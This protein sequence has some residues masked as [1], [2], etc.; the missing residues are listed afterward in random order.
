MKKNPF[1]KI[2]RQSPQ[3]QQQIIEALVN[4]IRKAPLNSIVEVLQE[5][6]LKYSFDFKTWLSS[7]QLE[8]KLTRTF[9]SYLLYCIYYNEL[10]FLQFDRLDKDQKNF[11]LLKLYFE[12]DKNPQLPKLEE[13]QLLLLAADCIKSQRE[14]SYFILQSMEDHLQGSAWRT[15]LRRLKNGY[16]SSESLYKHAQ[17]KSATF[18]EIDAKMNMDAAD[19]V[20]RI[21]KNLQ[22]CL[23]GITTVPS[24]W[25]SEKEL[26]HLN[27]LFKPFLTEKYTV[28]EAA[29]FFEIFG[30]FG[31][32]IEEASSSSSLNG[33]L[34][35]F[36]KLIKDPT[37]LIQHFSPVLFFLLSLSRQLYAFLR[38]PEQYLKGLERITLSVATRGNNLKNFFWIT[39]I[40]D[41]L[42]TLVDHLHQNGFTQVQ[43]S[44]FPLYVFDEYKTN[45]Q[46]YN[47][48]RKKYNATIH[49]IFYPTLKKVADLLSLTTSIFPNNS[50]KLGYAGARNCSLMLAPYLAKDAPEN[51]C[52][53]DAPKHYR[54]I[55]FEGAVNLPF[56]HVGEDDVYIP[57]SG[58]FSDALYAYYYSD[59][60]IHRG[61]M[62]YGRAGQS[63]QL[64]Q[65]L[66]SIIN[67][68]SKAFSST[69]W[70][71][72]P[73]PVL[74]SGGL[75]K[76][77]FCLNLPF[78]AEELHVNC[79][80]AGV[81]YFQ[82]PVIHLA[83]TR[84][85][86]KPLPN[87]PLDGIEETLNVS[88]PYVACVS[89]VINLVDPANKIF[90][91]ILPWNEK[92]LLDSKALR[93]L[94]EMLLFA[95]ADVVTSDIKKRFWRNMGI[96]FNSAK[97]QKGDFR[98]YMETLVNLDEKLAVS[99][100]LMDFYRRIKR[101]AKLFLE[102]GRKTLAY[103]Y[104]GIA[105]PHEKAFA[106]LGVTEMDEM[107]SAL[108][109]LI[110]RVVNETLVPLP[111]F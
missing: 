88:L 63:L 71:D 21:L 54:A 84:F 72:K 104:E 98:E 68:P 109:M 17:N 110:D 79:L 46:F 45:S 5:L 38:A 62:R 35:D 18:T 77:K 7:V 11:F 6:F 47:K 8:G 12:N 4:S 57:L 16:Y 20:K 67:S 22:A 49:T 27:Q 107:S 42:E 50:N 82:K 97:P 86:K 25:F 15:F 29:K 19:N 32:Y 60:F 95:H 30:C 1:A 66:Q 85:P 81:D 3:A 43:V 58:M 39:S 87:H 48:L 93:T 55:M 26:G 99:E 101:D 14:G 31:Y 69:A 24:T 90:R 100:E 23:K 75:T 105:N 41:S 96:V 34:E 106:E 28:K 80:P 13:N 92:E 10:N 74:M 108:F 65:D 83:G 64:I 33:I 40:L 76:P 103:A 59:N 89:M 52:S 51:W 111:K 78:G 9:I 56:V 36:L 2:S 44:S 53:N 61:T 94:L 73:T 102:L 37:Q 91:C 70:I